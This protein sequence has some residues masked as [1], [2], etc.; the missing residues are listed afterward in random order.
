MTGMFY[1]F[2][3]TSEIRIVMFKEH[4]DMLNAMEKIQKEPEK[5]SDTYPINIW[6]EFFATDIEIT[7][8]K[9]LDAMYAGVHIKFSDK[10]SDEDTVAFEIV[11]PNTVWFED[12][13]IH[14]KEG[15]YTALKSIIKDLGLKFIGYNNSKRFFHIERS[16]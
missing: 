8:N 4:G 9:I 2:I 13:I 10:D 6:E 1:K 16:V 5:Y 12:Y 11:L 7:V 14:M 3:P 15:F